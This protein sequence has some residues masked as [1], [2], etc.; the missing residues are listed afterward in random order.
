MG[1]RSAE[2][3]QSSRRETLTRELDVIDAFLTAEREVNL[4]LGFRRL[5]LC[6]GLC[7]EMGRA[8]LCRS[9]I[10]SLRSF[11]LQDGQQQDELSS[12]LKSC[13]NKQGAIHFSR[14]FEDTSLP[15]KLEVCS[16]TGDWVCAQA[17]HEL[18]AANWA[19][20]EW[21]YDRVHQTFS[22]ALLGGIDNLVLI[23][24]DASLV[25]PQRILPGTID[26]VFVNHP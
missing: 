12:A 8:E 2:A 26:A 1:D 17:R 6:R 15:L 19:A 22:R 9:L 14:L 24:G 5:L 11:G 3:F 18:G 20:L 16:G 25:L 10:A 23:G 4:G 7:A 13:M 21:R